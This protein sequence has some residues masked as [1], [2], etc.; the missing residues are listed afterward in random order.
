[1]LKEVLAL[2]SSLAALAAPAP[3]TDQALASRLVLTTR[4]LPGALAAQASSGLSPCAAPQRQRTAAAF[5]RFLFFGRTEIVSAASVYATAA[6]ARAAATGS[7]R[8]LASPCLA[9]TLG[10]AYE[11]QGAT[12]AAGTTAVARVGPAATRVR[13]HFVLRDRKRRTAVGVY[14]VVLLQRGRA[15]A[16]VAFV[17]PIDDAWERRVVAK[18]AARLP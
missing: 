1:M 16:G 18:V 4:D 17:N 13:L 6:G 11:Q 7:V 3:P 15:V 10:A 12:F 9:R 8:R 2:G 14:D 5:G